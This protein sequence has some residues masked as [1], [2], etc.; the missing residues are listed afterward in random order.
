MICLECWTF[1]NGF[2]FSSDV[3]WV[4]R[5]VRPHFATAEI[6]ATD[7]V[8]AAYFT[9]LQYILLCTKARFTGDLW[10][11]VSNAV[12][13][14]DDVTLPPKG[15]RRHCRTPL[16]PRG[17]AHAQGVSS[18]ARFVVLIM[19]STRYRTC[20]SQSELWRLFL[21][22]RHQTPFTQQPIHYFCTKHHSIWRLRNLPSWAHC[23]TPCQA[24]ARKGEHLSAVAA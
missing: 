22:Y 24:S 18:S 4:Y 3:T 1:S 9:P 2:E 5:N 15:G 23:L 7:D 12:L 20:C 13:S 8:N 11:W 6:A 14:V 17:C 21:G 10:H 16:L 19:R